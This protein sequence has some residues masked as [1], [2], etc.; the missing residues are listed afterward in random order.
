MIV[1]DS[2][3]LSLL[4]HPENP[5][6]Q[7]C[8]VGQLPVVGITQFITQLRGNYPILTDSPFAIG[9]YVHGART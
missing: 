8:P 1:L 6:T 4:Q 5:Q 3:H 2:D 7:L 9:R